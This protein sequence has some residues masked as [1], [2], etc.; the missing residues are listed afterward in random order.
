MGMGLLP[1]ALLPALGLVQSALGAVARV[2]QI[3]LNFRQRHTGNQ[4]V[5]TWGMSL[6]GNLVRIITTLA[7][8]DDTIALGGYLVAAT[9]N[10]TLVLQILI[11][12]KK[13]NEEVWGKKRK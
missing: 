8:V 9:L 12:W 1:A 10:G 7:A 6:A 4:S 2:P 5:I 3:V 11:F 13:T